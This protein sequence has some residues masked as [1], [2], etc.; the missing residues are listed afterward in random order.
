VTSARYGLFRQGIDIKALR[1]K[2]KL[3]PCAAVI[4]TAAFTASLALADSTNPSYPLALHGVWFDD[5]SKGTAKCRAYK[6]AGKADDDELSRLLVGAVLIRKSMIH[7]YAEYGEGNFYELRTLE[8][9]GRDSW[10]IAVAVGID[11]SPETSQPADDTFTMQLVRGR[12]TIRTK[13]HLLDLADSWKVDY[14]LRR[15]TKFE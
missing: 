11:T 8:K 10:R 13:P 3:L 1:S 7:D 9:T 12:L 2:A 5:S 4:V 14:R 6:K 15:C